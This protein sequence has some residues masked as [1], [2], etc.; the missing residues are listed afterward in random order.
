MKCPNYHFIVI[1]FLQP[2]VPR[3]GRRVLS[4]ISERHSTC[5]AQLW[6]SLYSLVGIFPSCS[7]YCVNNSL[8]E[9]N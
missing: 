5:V 9:E 3:M 1:Y 4:S 7:V 6:P 2:N 8:K